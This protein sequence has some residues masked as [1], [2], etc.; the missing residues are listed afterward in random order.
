L[1]GCI[2]G[3]G[4]WDWRTCLC[5][6]NICYC[7]FMELEIEQTVSS[8]SMRRFFSPCFTQ[9]KN[10]MWLGNAIHTTLVALMLYCSISPFEAQIY[11]VNRKRAY[12]G[13][14]RPC[15]PTLQSKVLF[16]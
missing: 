2:V 1:N 8:S 11:R 16:G 14:L 13:T 6:I 5:S 12:P 7:I 15:L 9:W 3:V 4:T 10:K